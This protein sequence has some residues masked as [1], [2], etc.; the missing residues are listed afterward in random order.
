MWNVN[1]VTRAARVPAAAAAS[2]VGFLVMVGAPWISQSCFHRECSFNTSC[3]S[4]A[5]VAAESCFDVWLR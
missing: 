3:S 2:A 1:A 5:L 4:V